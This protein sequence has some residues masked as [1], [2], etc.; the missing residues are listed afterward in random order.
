MLIPLVNVQFSGL[1]EV[2]LTRLVGLNAHIFK[3]AKFI[4]RYEAASDINMLLSQVYFAVASADNILRLLRMW[5]FKFTVIVLV[6]TSI[7]SCIHL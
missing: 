7:Y 6:N 1:F 4:V 2:Y 5:E 3:L